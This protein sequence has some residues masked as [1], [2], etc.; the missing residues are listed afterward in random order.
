MS[1]ITIMKHP[2]IV[3]HD[4]AAFQ[5]ETAAYYHREAALHHEQGEHDEAEVD[6]KSALAHSQEGDKLTKSAHQFSQK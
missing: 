3:P 6:A 4:N 2:A 1:T 5:H